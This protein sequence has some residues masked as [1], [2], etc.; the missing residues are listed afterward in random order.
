[1]ATVTTFQIAQKL[2]GVTVCVTNVKTKEYRVGTLMQLVP[3]LPVILAY[4]GSNGKPKNWQSPPAHSLV[5]TADKDIATEIVSEKIV[6]A[7][8]GEDGIFEIRSVS[9]TGDVEVGAILTEQV[10]C[11]IRVPVRVSVPM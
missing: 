8:G 2:H 6:A 4:I 3:G 9:F 10:Y 11:S 7:T 5:G 1:M